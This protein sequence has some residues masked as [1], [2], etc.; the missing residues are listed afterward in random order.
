MAQHPDSS[1]DRSA[2]GRTSLAA[3]RTELAWWRTGLTALA[4]AIG[5]GRVVPELQDSGSSWPYIALGVGFAAYGIACFVRGSMR[6][7]EVPEAIGA[8]SPNRVPLEIAI[9]A[10]GPVLG[11]AVIALI[12]LS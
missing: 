1:E 12:A 7:R 3:E 2:V 9:A 11:L 5:V 8:P 6:S 4:V 10:A